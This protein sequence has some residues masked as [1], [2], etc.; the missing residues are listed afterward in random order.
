MWRDLRGTAGALGTAMTNSP[1]IAIS[2]SDL[3]DVIGGATRVASGGGT[4][5]NN[6]ALLQTVT[7]LQSSISD[8]A[9]NNQGGDQTMMP[10]MMMMAMKNRQG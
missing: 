1:F 8:L 2:P 7:Q 4:Q 6:T 5:D 9:K 3:C 10:M